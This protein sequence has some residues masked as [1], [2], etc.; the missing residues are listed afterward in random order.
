MIYQNSRYTKTGVEDRNG[1]VNLKLRTRFNFGT[2]GTI[3][4]QYALGDRLDGLANIYYKDPQLW[5]VI[6][7]ANTQFRSELE[8]PYGTNLVIPSYIEVMKCLN[9]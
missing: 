4:H 3:V 8:I 9:Y 1:Q 6:L 7:E 5:W 2:D